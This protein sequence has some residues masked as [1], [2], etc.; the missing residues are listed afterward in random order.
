MANVGPIT[1]NLNNRK[2]ERNGLP[3]NNGSRP[4]QSLREGHSNQTT[5][6]KT[7]ATPATNPNEAKLGLNP[8]PGVW[9]MVNGKKYLCFWLAS[10]LLH[11]SR[12]GRRGW[13]IAPNTATMAMEDKGASWIIKNAQKLHWQRE[14]PSASQRRFPGQSSRNYWREAPRKA[15]P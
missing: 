4:Q 9:A 15:D 3:S 7:W 10:D 2:S 11:E 13:T 14:H 1:G 6:A 5:N 8:L 12:S